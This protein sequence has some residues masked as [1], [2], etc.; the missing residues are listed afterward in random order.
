MRILASILF[1]I[2]VSLSAAFVYLYSQITFDASN[3]IDFKP[4][5][6]TQIYDRNGELIANIFDE[7]RIY[8]KY[9]DIPPRVIEALVA[10]E[11]TSF[12]EH[13]GVNP[14]SYR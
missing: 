6:T 7:N 12:F 4:K 3:I 9:E 1:I 14:E 8:V 11:D 5:L 2:F 10:I 13:G